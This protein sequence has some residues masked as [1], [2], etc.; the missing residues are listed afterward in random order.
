MDGTSQAIFVVAWLKVSD[1]R[2]N[3]NMYYNDYMP[4]HC[5]VVD[6]HGLLLLSL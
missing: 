4:L 1:H 3:Y 2:Y 5:Y 6:R